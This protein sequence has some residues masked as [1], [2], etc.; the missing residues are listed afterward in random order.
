VSSPPLFKTEGAFGV[1][2]MGATSAIAS[3]CARKWAE[4]GARFFLVGR[5]SE[6]LQQ[7]SSDL[8][9]RGA[10]AVTT[11]LLD[12]NQFAGHHGMLDACY[13][14]LGQIDIALI[15]H[16]SWP[17]QKACERDADLALREFSNNALSVISLLTQ[18]ANRMQAHGSGTI[19][20]I[21]SVAGDRG[22]SS[23]YLYGS[24]KAAVSTFS[25]GLRTRLCRSGV[26]VLTVKPG[27]VDTPMIQGR[28]L[29]KFLVATP[30]KVA[31]DIVR[32]VACKKNAIYT[33]S[34]WAAIMMIVRCLPFP[35]FKRIKV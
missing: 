8:V 14:A 16:G 32:A 13:G 31:R 17:D 12:F 5:N 2:I 19:A 1:V 30:E 29:P 15:A 10:S 33:P 4:K 25:E 7:V 26:H 3:A 28:S 22:R 11:H 27:L 21:S 9:A 18:L 23:N 24:A 6:K 35:I 34:F 20:V